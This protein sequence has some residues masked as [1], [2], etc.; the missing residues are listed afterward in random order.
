VQPPDLK[1]L[2]DELSAH[3]D[4]REVAG[5]EVVVYDDEHVYLP[6]KYGLA[7]ASLHPADTPIHVVPRLNPGGR[8]EKTAE[9]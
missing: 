2:G 3:Q 1:E 4:R 6:K 8:P 5:C 9:V 7:E